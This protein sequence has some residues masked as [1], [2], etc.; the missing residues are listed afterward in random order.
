MMDRKQE[1][2]TCHVGCGKL[3]ASLILV[4]KQLVFI[5]SSEIAVINH[6]VTAVTNLDQF[7]A[8]KKFPPIPRQGFWSRRNVCR[9]R[10]QSVGR[11]INSAAGSDTK[12]SRLFSLFLSPGSATSTV[13]HKRRMESPVAHK[14]SELACKFHKMRICLHSVVSNESWGYLFT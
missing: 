13:I 1:L 9:S 6:L 10:Q 8:P 2:W 4:T 11:A 12:R 5:A 3:Q 7:C 14:I